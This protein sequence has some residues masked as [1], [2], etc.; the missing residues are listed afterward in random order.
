MDEAVRTDAFISEFKHWRDVRGHSQTT[1]AKKMGFTRSYISKIETG[2]E[3][4]TRSFAAKAEEVL[5]SGGALLRALREAEA[6]PKAGQVAAKTPIVDEADLAASLVVVHDHARLQYDGRIYTAT[7]RRELLNAGSEPI[8]RYLVRIAV[9]RYPES[10][11]RSNEHYRHNPLTWS[12]LELHATHDDRDRMPWLVRH[13]R[14]AFKEIWLLFENEH[15]R[16]PLYPRESTVIEYTYNVSDIKWGRW[17]QRAVRLPTRRLSVELDFP[18]DLEPRVWGTQTSLAAAATALPTAILKSEGG[19]RSIFA[20]STED[21][22]LHARFRM[23]WSFGTQPDKESPV[24]EPPSPSQ[25]M[26]QLGVVQEG[27]P[28]L[29]QVTRQFDLPTESAAAENL[30]EELRGAMRR[31]GAVHP[32]RKGMGLAAPQIGI[33]RA[34]AIVLTPEGDEVT[35]LNPRVIGESSQT[36]EQYEGCMS[37]FDVRGEVPRPLMIEVEHQTPDGSRVITIFERGHARLIMHEIDHLNGKVYRDRMRPGVEPISVSEYK[38]T[39][40]S[41]RY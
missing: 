20:W 9:D 12:E 2:G 10:P 15:S 37:F 17:F 35:L 30:L 29:R 38:G 31:I 4:P 16:F 23:E 24:D 5:N 3:P 21:P 41:W 25:V 27:D 28:V 36:D 18:T 34:A 7:Q 32:F 19:G 11:T 14:D 6:P 13:D 1:L 8:T 26:S 33:D 39:G 22:P 40:R